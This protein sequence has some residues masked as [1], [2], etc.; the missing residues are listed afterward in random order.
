M[1]PARAREV[2]DLLREIRDAMGL[3]VNDVA[4]R[5]GWSSSKVSRVERG[6][7]EIDPAELVRY[8]AYCGAHISD[9]DFLL[10]WC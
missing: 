3:T 1:A 2:G 7:S 5:L 8:A 9:I 4:D 6:V 10:D